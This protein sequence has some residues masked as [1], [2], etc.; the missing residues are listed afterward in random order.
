MRLTK[1][2]KTDPWE[3]TSDD[4]RE[5]DALTTMYGRL[6]ATV[7]A[8]WLGVRARSVAQYLRHKYSPSTTTN[9]LVDNTQRGNP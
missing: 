1:E 7:I 8:E 2:P 6:D 9:H 3:L 4:K 5:I